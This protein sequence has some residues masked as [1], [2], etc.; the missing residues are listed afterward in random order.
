MPYSAEVVRRARQSLAQRKAD[1]ESEY[2]QH[3]Y[4]A[5][6]AVPRLREIDLELRRSMT[7]A[8]QAVFTQ[9]GD[10]YAAMEQVKQANLALQEERSRLI[11]EHFAPGYLDD[12]PVCGGCDGNG[13]IGSTMCRCLK[14]LCRQEQKK[15]LVQL[16]NGQECF[17]AFR[18]DYYPDRIDRAYGA[19]PRTIMERNLQVC[20]RYA[21]AFTDGIG[22]LLFVGGT[23]LGKTFLSACI[24]NEVADKGFSVAYESAPHLLSKLEK[25]RFSPDEESRAEAAKFASCDLLI[26]DD[27]GTEMPGNFVTAALYTLLND[28]LLSGKSMI[29]STNLNVDEIARR[30][31]PQIASRL[32][33]SFKGLT[34][35]GD[36]IR[37]LK[38]RGV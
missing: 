14:E 6:G 13:Y 16:T 5:Y 21:E 3:L 32:Q 10:A 37:V 24:A 26:I 31:S 25:N 30:Y 15:E 19:S 29:I 18:L 34:F 17:G 11:T 1:K 9:G 12:S 8:A 20:R 27:L 22:N 23:G 2:H 33:G 35:V 36:D 28:R 7:L 38:N 4:E